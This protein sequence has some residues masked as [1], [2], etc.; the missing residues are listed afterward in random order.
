LQLLEAEEEGLC[1]DP[2]KQQKKL[3]D[4]INAGGERETAM[5]EILLEHYIGSI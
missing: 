3:R 4:S 2:L 1:R 5:W